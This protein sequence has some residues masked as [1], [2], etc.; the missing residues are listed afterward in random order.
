M[1]GKRII[2]VMLLLS[3]LITTVQGEESTGIGN[4]ILQIKLTNKEITKL[5]TQFTADITQVNKDITTKIDALFTRIALLVISSILLII[6]TEKTIGA[7]IRYKHSRKKTKEIQ[8]LR[9]KDETLIELQ[10]E[11]IQLIKDEGVPKIKTE[12][13]LK[14]SQWPSLITAALIGALV[15]CVILKIGGY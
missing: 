4:L 14:K 7:L 11:L 15:V 5:K 12:T 3:V 6:G 8:K 9:E 10:K 1:Q 13:K 2:A